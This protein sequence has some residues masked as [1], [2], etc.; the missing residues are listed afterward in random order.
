MIPFTFHNRSRI[1]CNVY[2]TVYN[3]NIVIFYSGR[4]KRDLFIRMPARGTR[5]TTNRLL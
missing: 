4:L 2:I 1:H 5:D 3:L